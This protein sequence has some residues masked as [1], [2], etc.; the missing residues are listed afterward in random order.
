MPLFR[1]L[2][3]AGIMLQRLPSLFTTE[4]MCLSNDWSRLCTTTVANIWVH[5]MTLEGSLAMTHT[6]LINQIDSRKNC[7]GSLLIGSTVKA[8]LQKQLKTELL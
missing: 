6:V 3:V 2:G 4:L 8:Q 5:S 1:R 7:Q